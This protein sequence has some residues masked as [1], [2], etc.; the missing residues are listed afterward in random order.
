MPTCT[1]KIITLQVPEALHAQLTKEAE[2]RMLS[3]SAYI[4]ILI[5]NRDTENKNSTIY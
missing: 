3:L 2:E 1:K 4:R 5:Q